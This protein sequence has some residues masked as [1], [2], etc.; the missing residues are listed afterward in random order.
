MVDVVKVGIGPGSA[1]TTRL[2]TGVG[3]PQLSAIL[4][5]AD[6]AHGV[7]GHIIADGGITCPGDMAKAF[8]GGADFVMV[9]GQFAGHDQNP[10]EIIEE[11]NEFSIVKYRER[12]LKV[13][14]LKV[15]TTQE[16]DQRRN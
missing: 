3:M 1:C 4:E 7:D 8:G 5:C 15:E 2:K 6:A 11:N 12:E 16:E 13:K 10:G 14:K 9:G